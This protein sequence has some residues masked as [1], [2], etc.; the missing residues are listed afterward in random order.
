MPDLNLSARN[1][2]RP[3]RPNLHRPPD[4]NK[5]M[6]DDKEFTAM[7]DPTFLAERARVREAIEAL[8]E[9]ARQL[10]AEFDRRASIAWH[11]AVGR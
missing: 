3:G 6:D 8:R 1:Q 5:A 4:E 7:D 9:R 2:R 10:D 11:A